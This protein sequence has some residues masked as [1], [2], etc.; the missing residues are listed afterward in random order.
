MKNSIYL[1]ST[2]II[3]LLSS[4]GENLDCK[5][6]NSNMQFAKSQI[7]EALL[8][9]DLNK[10]RFF[11]FRALNIL[12]KSKDKLKQCGCTFAKNSMAESLDLLILSTKSI[13]L[14]GA[15]IYLDQSME[16]TKNTILTIDAH[17]SHTSGNPKGDLVLNTNSIPATRASYAKGKTSTIKNKIDISLEKY[18][19]SLDKV[20]ENVNCKDA[21]AFAQRIFEECENQL[22]KQDLSEGKKYYNLRTK[23][24]TKEALNKI[25]SCKEEPYL[26]N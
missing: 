7:K 14:K 6:V 2:F 9:N 1:V 13:T 18:R 3:L 11:T 8:T 17:A 16:L 26:T 5:Y 10:A 25:G 22:L 15:K 21:K 20:V 23:E 12:E 24:I 4:F 19:I